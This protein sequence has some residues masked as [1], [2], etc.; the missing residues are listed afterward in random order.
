MPTDF[1]AP[2]ASGLLDPAAPPPGIVLNAE[3]ASVAKRYNVYRNN[4]T[5][6]LIA[7]VAAIYPAVQ[8]IVGED[9]FRAMARAH[10]R[11]T[12]PSSPLLFDYG[13][14]F[15]AF[16]A[17]YPYAAEMPWLADVA[18]IE[19]AWL[20]AYHAADAPA[21]A[22]DDL[23][24]LP[25]QALPDLQLRAH[26][27]AQVVRSAYPAVSIFAINRH[28]GPVSPLTTRDAQIAL[29]TR[30][31][32]EVI[33]THL[34]DEAAPFLQALLDGQPLASAAEAALSANPSFD[35]TTHL[36]ALI[37]AGV[38]ASLPEETVA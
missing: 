34:P 8:R 33:V 32:D 16:I 12:P 31:A 23:A 18:R 26:P 38:F 20:D 24:A 10:V 25:A 28:E 14:A 30:P 37:E 6:S 27:A 19:R 3:G 9:F 13:R 36:A 4:V 11:E 5:V 35:L 29:V 21:L 1:A 22:A 15:P 17:A 7:A 2:L